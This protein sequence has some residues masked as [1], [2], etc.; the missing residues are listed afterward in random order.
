MSAFLKRR[1]LL[2][3]GVPIALLV[4]ALVGLLRA[5]GE[6]P[7]DNPGTTTDR[8]FNSPQFPY[9]T[10]YP[11]IA[12]AGTNAAE[13][14][15]TGA[16]AG[17][18]SPAAKPVLK[19]YRCASGSAE[20]AAARLQEK[21]GGNPGVRIVPDARTSQVLVIAPPNVQAEIA[22][23]MPEVEPRDVLHQ[24]PAAA[25][26]PSPLRPSAS[27]RR[28]R[29]SQEIQLWHTTGQEFEAALVRM[30]GD[31]LT[32][33]SASQPDAS[34]YQLA[35]A[36]GRTMELSINRGLNRVR[37][38]GSADAVASS[39]Q[40]IH[41]L[42]SPQ[43]PAGRATRLVSLNAARSADVR[44]V[45]DALGSGPSGRVGGSGRAPTPGHQKGFQTALVIAEPGPAR[46]ALA[47]EAAAGATSAAPGTEAGQPATPEAAAAP[48]EGLEEV[49]G[50]LGPV[51]VEIIPGTD[52][53]VISGH[54]RD[55]QRVVE[56]IEEIEKISKEAE[57]AVAVYHLVH[58]DCIPL[59]AL[60]NQL[61]EDVYS[62]RQGS[63]SITALV[64]PNALLLIGRD[65]N[66][67]TVVD[68]VKRLD[69]PVP[70]STQFRVFRLKNTPAEDAQETIEDFFTDRYEEEEGGLG[71]R[72]QVTADF[73]TNSLIV[74]AS[75]RDL[76][77][78]AAIIARLDEPESETFNEVRIFKLKNSLAEDLAPVLQ[79]A[80]TG[81]MYG[82]RTGQRA[83]IQR[84]AGV[85]ESFERKSIRLQFLSTDGDGQARLNSGILTDVQVTADT[86]ANALIVTASADSMPLIAALIKELD[87]LP[88]AEAQV[89]VFTVVYGDATNLL[90]MLETLFGA[91]AQA[92]LAVRT[93][94]TGEDSSLVNLRFAVDVRTNSIIATGSAGDLEVV[95]AI[96]M[97]LD[98]SDLRERQTVVIRL[99]NAS[100]LDISNAVNDFLTSELEAEQPVQGL[101]SSIEQIDREVV[102]VPEEITNSLIVSATERFF[103]RITDLVEKLDSRPP[104][105]LIQ[106]LIAAVTLNDTDE[107]GVEL[108]LQDSLLF[109]RS[110]AGAGD[111]AGTSI[112]GFLFNSISPLGNSN[113]A[114][115]LA[116]S[117]NVGGQGLTNLSLGRSNSE[118]GYG[119]L[120]LSASS[121]SVSVLI[122]ALKENR[123]LDVLGR[124]Q[125]MT[126]DNVRATIHVG[127]N[128]PTISS[129]QPATQ[130]AT[131]T[132]DVEFVTVGL[133]LDVLPRIN[134][135]GLVVMEITAIRSKL[136]PEEEGIPISVAADGTT[137]RSPRIDI[138][139][140]QT[141]VSAMD[142]QTVVMGGL[143]TK[144]KSEVH[145]Q[146]PW[147]GDVPVLGR[148]FRVDSVT[149]EKTELLIILTPHVID[150]DEDAE[151]IKRV[152]AARMQW[153]LGDVIE[154][155]GDPFAESGRASDDSQ[156]TVI[157]PDLDP[158]A[159]LINA[160]H[161]APEADEAA[162]AQP[163]DSPFMVE[164]PPADA[165]AQQG[166]AVPQHPT[167]GPLEGP[168]DSGG[169][170]YVPSIGG[171]DPPGRVEEAT[172][173][174]D[175]V[176]SYR[177][178]S[179]SPPGQ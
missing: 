130:L 11:Q 113:S 116:R 71:T 150:N 74:W 41:V 157:Y 117:E 67:K 52:I 1:K 8:Q 112:P 126:V 167:N 82:Q 57:P 91:Q 178:P 3:L 109:D 147:L 94:A 169:N 68:L 86:R 155:H 108:G 114:G 27:S 75:P 128:V 154:M 151:R 140:A 176:P 19:V 125:I 149:E 170:F 13:V 100:A 89:K 131:Q 102:I 153:C 32:P 98:E 6:V 166:A 172:Y 2:V 135:D 4:A 72:V 24:P 25:G 53:V 164:P 156:T 136:G 159:E 59:A 61:Y 142:G 39:M 84:A 18:V 26:R 171:T 83:L 66:V 141:T 133:Q 5:G 120:V 107:F 78:V 122:R 105:V 179:S 161:L 110:V 31:R 87:A 103:D 33:T 106:V 93:G 99:K 97:R 55:V 115:A 104:M 63:V 123:R 73:R 43:P 79:D 70:P 127:E 47:E 118:L 14:G 92:D 15:E 51:Q 163:E 175:S 65:E 58:T 40:L 111:L 129:V 60:L 173:T 62:T 148:L 138:V 85:A 158:G 143:I 46:A 23:R 17:P 145:R 177:V 44:L 9:F 165:P 35:L 96:L 77:E 10:G 152:E 49:G 37:V 119:G 56:M 80:I 81:Q 22:A 134:V 90:D 146:V 42:D 132:Y 45:V 137:I 144:D 30:L 54:E 28:G 16:S 64:K 7:P 95:E 36:K 162:P 160:P 69:R 124:P 21:F 48:A 76:G 174:P 34:S 88:T 50:M 121:E 168:A 20:A 139:E 12:Q 29:S 101:L 38:E